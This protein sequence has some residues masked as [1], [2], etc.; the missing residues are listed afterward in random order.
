MAGAYI[1]C[2]V[3]SE[4]PA[5]DTAAASLQSVQTLACYKNSS[6]TTHYARPAASARWTDLLTIW[7]SQLS[8]ATGLT[9]GVTYSATTHRVTMTGSASIRPVMVGNGALFTGFTQT[10]TPSAVSWLA[11]SPPAGRADLLGAMVEPAEDW[12]HVDLTAYRHGSSRATA[13]G[14]LQLHRCTLYATGDAIT[15]IQIGYLQ[16]GRVRLYQGNAGD[17]LSAYGPGNPVGYVDG[18][19]IGCGPGEEQS[20][21]LWVYPMLLGVAR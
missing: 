6:G 20:E 17:E 21:N 5:S 13:W 14:N 3:Y 2:Y 15:A 8:T 7:A 10:L 12:A 1:E 11:A 9:I 4:G 18:Y 19:V 16:A